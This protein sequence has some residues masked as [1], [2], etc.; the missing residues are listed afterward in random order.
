MGY[1]T[2]KFD[3]EIENFFQF[4]FLMKVITLEQWWMKQWWVDMHH[5]CCY[6]NIF[7]NVKRKYS[8]PKLFCQIMELS[9][10]QSNKT[11]L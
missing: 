9:T 11:H 3:I 2:I 10:K 8:F 5:P 6:N 4:I 7:H 1:G